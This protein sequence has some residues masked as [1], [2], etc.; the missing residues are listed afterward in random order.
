[1]VFH[2]PACSFAKA[3]Q[4]FAMLSVLG[5]EGLAEQQ[6]HP[7]WTDLAGDPL[8]YPRPQKSIL[9]VPQVEVLPHH[10]HHPQDSARQ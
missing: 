1:M 5:R 9:P 6:A 8:H 4:V 7:P 3:I 2:P 10:R